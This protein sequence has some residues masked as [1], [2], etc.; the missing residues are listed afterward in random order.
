MLDLDHVK[1]ALVGVGFEMRAVGIKHAPV[2]HATPDC[3][4]DDLIKNVLVDTALGKATAA[5]LAQCRCI[6]HLVGQT[7]SQKPAVGNIDLDFTH[8]LPLATNTKQVAQQQTFE[9]HHRIQCR[10]AIV[11]A[12]QMG[13]AL[14]DEFQ[15]DRLGDLAH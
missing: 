9:Q 5:I 8:E 11:G 14:T 10:A 6:G 1:F 3:L 4:Q 2:H 12:I 15:I 13:D 7:Q